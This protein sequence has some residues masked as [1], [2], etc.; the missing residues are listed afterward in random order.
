MEIKTKYN[1][2]DKVWIMRNNKPEKIQISNIEVEV[3]GDVPVGTCS[4]SGEY[5][6][7]IIYV[8][9][10]RSE[11]RSFGDKDPICK[12]DECN[13]F[14]TKKD[15]LYSFL[16]DGTMAKKKQTS[17]QNY[18]CRDCKHAFDFHE[19]NWKGEPF[20]CKCPFHKYSKFLDKDYCTNFKLK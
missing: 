13:C 2:G 20:L 7:Q 12:H 14:N 16:D 10:Q 17:T 3:I 9:V 11:Y 6:T 15:L 1:V 4:L 18:H 5:Y 8:E 19:L